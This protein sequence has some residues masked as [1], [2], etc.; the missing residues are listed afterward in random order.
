MYYFDFKPNHIDSVPHQPLL[1]N[2][3]EMNNKKDYE[4][5]LKMRDTEFDSFSFDM[6]LSQVAN[7]SQDSIEQ[8][9]QTSS[10]FTLNTFDELSHKQS[11]IFVWC[12]FD[13]KVG[14]E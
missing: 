11:N 4:F 2:H 13:S 3:E 7:R 5:L 9:V 1:M 14:N 6:S 8:H 10:L 12:Q